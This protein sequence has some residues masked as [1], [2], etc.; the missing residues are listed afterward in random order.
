MSSILR[1]VGSQPPGVYWRR[2]IL[3]GAG[4]LVILLLIG[5][6]CDGNAQTDGQPATPGLTASS[7]PSPSATAIPATTPLAPTP[8][9]QPSS[10]A[11]AVAG[12]TCADAQVRV[13]V[14]AE[15]E[16]NPVGGPARVRFV[17]A[18]TSATPC[19]RDV[20]RV[21]NEVQVRSGNR[22]IWSSD[23]CAPG[24]ASTLREISRTTPF[25][26]TVEWKGQIS[27]PGCPKGQPAAPAGSYSWV[28]RNGSVLS[29]SE[30][31]TLG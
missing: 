27:K 3:L 30:P 26:V 8:T 13:Y 14:T 10:S 29:D 19:L 2:R 16:Q 28:G 17:V 7:T 23:D 15:E 9:V 24:G 18:T 1:P 5:R 31:F 21:R 12:Q 20:G 11:P 22:R 25:A 6:A 4:V